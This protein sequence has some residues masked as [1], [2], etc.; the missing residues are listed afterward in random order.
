MGLNRK[1]V[2]RYFGLFPTLIHAHQTNE[3]A[4]FVGVVE[5]DESFFS[6]ARIRG[7]PGPR[8]RG[9]GMLK[10]PVFGIYEQDGRVYNEIV[11][12]CSA[13]TL[14]DMIRGRGDPESVV[15]PDGWK[16]YDGLV[17][18]GYEKHLRVDHG[19]HQFGS[20]PAHI[21][22]IEGFLGFVKSRLT[23]FRGMNPSTFYLHYLKECE[24]RFNHRDQDLYKLI[25]K[26]I[27]KNA[28]F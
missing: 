4:Q 16:G 23:R 22:G 24:F 14:Q 2:N 8:M 3:K 20:G 1:I 12:D 10:Q 11:A 21:N 15:H 28:L 17:E 5:V 7:R 26:M 19:K 25:L 27:R 13:K 9:R 18:V 6:P